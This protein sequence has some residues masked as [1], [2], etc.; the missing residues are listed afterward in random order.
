MWSQS[1][2]S[3]CT[4]RLQDKRSM[5]SAV[6]QDLKKNR[7]SF[8]TVCCAFVG[9]LRCWKIPL[10]DYILELYSSGRPQ[11]HPAW[12]REDCRTKRPRMSGDPLQAFV[13]DKEEGVLRVLDQRQLPVSHRYI[14]VPNVPQAVDVIKNMNVCSMLYCQAAVGLLCN[15][16]RF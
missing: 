14:D 6:D 5:D 15:Q 10:Q 13:Y 2:M 3:L 9:A 7:F 4:L 12:R 11:G 8:A 16:Y 1:N